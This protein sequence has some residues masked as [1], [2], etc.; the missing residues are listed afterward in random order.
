MRVGLISSTL[1]IFAEYFRGH[2]TQLIM[3]LEWL[4]C[5]ELSFP[6]GPSQRPFGEISWPGREE[7]TGSG[8]TF[9]DWPDLP[10]ATR[11]SIPFSDFSGGHAKRRRMKLPTRCLKRVVMP[12]DAGK[13]R[14]ANPVIVEKGVETMLR[15]AIVD[16]KL[17]VG[18]Q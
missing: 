2:N 15:H 9:Q 12:H 18:Q 10:P 8:L 11:R 13:H 5:A 7:N 4:L 1:K 6:R 14:G 17:L 3:L 16:Q